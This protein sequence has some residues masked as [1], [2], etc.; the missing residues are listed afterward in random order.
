MCSSCPQFKLIRLIGPSKEKSPTDFLFPIFTF[1]NNF[2]QIQQF[3]IAAILAVA[4]A[5]P[6]GSSYSGSAITITAQS[7]V[8]NGDGSSQWRYK[9]F[10]RFL[11]DIKRPFNARAIQQLK[12]HYSLQSFQVMPGLTV[13]HVRNLRPNCPVER[14][15]VTAVV[16]PTREHPTTFHLKARK[17]V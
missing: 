11:T 4:V 3:V 1:P 15:T 2:V 9:R 17:S 16:T 5:A 6:S 12:I 7:D 13:P 10:F 14:T 8:R